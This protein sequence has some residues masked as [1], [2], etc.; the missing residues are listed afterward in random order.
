MSV[1]HAHSHRPRRPTHRSR[2]VD[3]TTL[4]LDARER[5]IDR[6]ARRQVRLRRR[7]AEVAAS[8][9]EVIVQVPGLIGRPIAGQRSG[10]IFVG[11]G[12][13]RFVAEALVRQA[14]EAAE[15]AHG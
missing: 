12:P 11:G 15:E 5:A 7:R 3:L 10:A 4:S 6:V 13:S 1:G 9:R 2:D 8:P 14:R